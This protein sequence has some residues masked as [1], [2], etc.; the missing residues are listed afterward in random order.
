MN[1][2]ELAREISEGTQAFY[3]IMAEAGRKN[4][5]F[6]C[7]E[8]LHYKDIKDE[9]NKE[10][11]KDLQALPDNPNDKRRYVL[12]ASKDTFKTT[13]CSVAFPLWLL[14]REDGFFG[15]N[16]TALLGN[17]NLEKSKGYLQE[18]KD[19]L[20]KNE[21]FRACYGCFDSASDQWNTGK[22]VVDRNAPS[23]EPTIMAISTKT[24]VSSSHPHLIVLDDWANEKN[25]QTPVG[26]EEQRRTFK[27]VIS[28]LRIG[29][30]IVL[31]GHRFHHLDI[32]NHLTEEHEDKAKWKEC[33]KLVPARKDG[34]EDGEV[35]FPERFGKN[36]EI[37]QKK[38]EDIGSVYLKCYYLLDPAGMK[39]QRFKDSWLRYVKA[40]E[41]PPDLIRM[42]GVD[43]CTG[44]NPDDPGT[45]YFATC[46]I[47]FDWR[48]N[49]AYLLEMYRKKLPFPEQLARVKMFYKMWQPERMFIESNQMQIA[50][51]QM[52][53]ID[54]EARGMKWEAV[55]N[56]KNKEIRLDGLTLVFERGN[57]FV[58][59]DMEGLLEFKKEY[60]GYPAEHDDQLDVLDFTLVN[61]WGIIQK[62]YKEHNR[63]AVK[64]IA[65]G[66]RE[67]M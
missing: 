24:S 67:R 37:L 52:L 2:E 49:L 17:A 21:D 5:L 11:C 20:Q 33:V 65:T 12:I 44:K 7:T 66:S 9:A 18:I 8:I 16:M 25:S 6:F 55:T 39:G 59:E 38:K 29:G 40:S 1:K 64:I 56:T 22:I 30:I 43:L 3:K 32:F 10:W 60:L 35:M 14:I 63:K 36:G 62:I 26:L 13:I 42:A 61:S 53:A 51:P 58:K 31:V 4:F 45:D 27:E 57:I 19:I 50:M 48:T 34:K 47:G 15:Q 46:C 54:P 41:L 28:T 23:K